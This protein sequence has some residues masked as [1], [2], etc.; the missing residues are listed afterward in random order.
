MSGCRLWRQPYT[1]DA[2]Q[3]NH[4]SYAFPWDANYMWLRS[5]DNTEKRVEKLPYQ[6]KVLNGQMTFKK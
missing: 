1:A 5:S 6:K 3:L 4:A 2:H